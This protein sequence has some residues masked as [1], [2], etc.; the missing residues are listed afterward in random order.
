M[1]ALGLAMPLLAAGGWLWWIYRSDRFEREPWPLVLKTAAL[2]AGAGLLSLLL[3]LTVWPWLH[4][5]LDLAWLLL[6]LL[7][8]PYRSPEWNEPYDG[9]VYGASAGVGYGLVYTMPALLVDRS[10]GFQIAI[11]SMPIYMMS[12]VVLGF[13]LS[14]LKQRRGPWPLL[15]GIAL[16]GGFLAGIELALGAGGSVVTGP[17]MLASL[18]AYGSNMAAWIFATRA[19]ELSNAASPLNLDGRR[20]RL[21]GGACP[22]CGTALVIAARYCSDCGEALARAGE[23]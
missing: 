4:T 15:R 7:A 18:M 16:A 11:F 1:A 14:R 10:L 20:I 2:G 3:S 23:G 6:V 21:S 12:G 5:P 22:V 17:N 8:L 13:H 19:M 9:L